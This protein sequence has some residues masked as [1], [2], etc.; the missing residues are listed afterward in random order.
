MKALF[1][2]LATVLGVG[3]LAQ[4][5]PLELG[6]V[7]ADANWLVHVDFDA[8]RAAKTAQS[9]HQKWLNSDPVKQRL[10]AIR[11]TIGMDPLEDFRSVTFYGSRLTRLKGVVIVRAKLDRQRL[12]DLLSLEPSHQVSSYGSH[13]LHTWIQHKAVAKQQ[14]VAGSFH[15]SET[16]V[17]GQ[18]PAEV[19]TALDV[20][21]GKAPKLAGSDSLLAED[22][23]PGT[24]LQVRAIGLAEADLDVRSP[25]LRQSDLLSLVVGEYEGEVFARAR[26]VAKTAKAADQIR[27]VVDGF[28]AV[29][30]LGAN[31]DENLRQVLDAMKVTKEEKTVTVECR[32]PHA[33]VFRFIE[34]AVDKQ[35]QKSKRVD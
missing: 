13:E 16:L 21:D 22:A 25:L 11:Q 35:S 30:S 33:D 27:A 7:S 24:V 34:K 15:G 17:L 12:L 1:A 6:Q 29:A 5:E 3:T 32:G 26:L 10:K 18:D 19:K 20:L 4:A 14:T 9:I 28:L 2:A 31:E 23:P 8:L